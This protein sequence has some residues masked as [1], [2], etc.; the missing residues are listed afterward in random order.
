ML[1]SGLVGPV[2]VPAVN[3]SV[4]MTI[5]LKVLLG[6]NLAELSPITF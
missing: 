1:T 4:G 2:L 6:Y 3:L 5:C